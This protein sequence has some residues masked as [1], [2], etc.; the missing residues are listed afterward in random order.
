MKCT[1]IGEPGFDLAA[2]QW[3]AWENGAYKRKH[4]VYGLIRKWSLDCIEENVAWNDSSA[5]YL[6]EQAATGSVLNYS[7]D[8][9]NRYTV[10][11]T[12]VY[13][14]NVSLRLARWIQEHTAFHSNRQR[15]ITSREQTTSETDRRRKP[16]RPSRRG[17]VRRFSGQKLGQWSRR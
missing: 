6:R 2:A 17:M 8:E 10:P 9:G 15:G 13:V 3:D 1:G 5:K 4:R 14:L 12:N 11:A 16:R 7:V